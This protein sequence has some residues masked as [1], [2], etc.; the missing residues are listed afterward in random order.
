MRALLLAA[1]QC[2]ANW[3]ACDTLLSRPEA[4]NPRFGNGAFHGRLFEDQ[5]VQSDSR[6][7][8][9]RRP[10]IQENRQLECYGF[11]ADNYSDVLWNFEKFLVDRRG[12]AISRFAPDM[13]PDDPV[14]LAAI[15]ERLVQP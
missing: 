12:S 3:I 14:I 8:V 5:G 11:G 13:P 2:H 7:W 1:G 15:D 6:K 9:H 4:N 10:E